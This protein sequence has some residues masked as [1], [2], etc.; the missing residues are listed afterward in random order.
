MGQ[1]F[2]VAQYDNYLDTLC[3]NYGFVTRAFLK[4][5]YDSD[6]SP[7]EF[8][9]WVTEQQDWFIE[10]GNIPGE[11]EVFPV[12]MS[13]FANYFTDDL[14]NPQSKLVT[15]ARDSASHECADYDWDAMQQGMMDHL[16]WLRNLL[17][18]KLMPADWDSEKTPETYRNIALG[19]S[20][21][22]N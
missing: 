18:P 12:L 7:E 22:L 14:L 15:G 4:E 21:R 6:L 16:T 2:A 10:S 19:V 1:I 3:D 17:V 9:E 8:E 20:H 13:A 11:P 5:K